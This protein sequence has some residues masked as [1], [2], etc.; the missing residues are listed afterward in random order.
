MIDW[1]ASELGD[2]KTSIA[3]TAAGATWSTWSRSNGPSASRC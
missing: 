2:D 1:T 3:R